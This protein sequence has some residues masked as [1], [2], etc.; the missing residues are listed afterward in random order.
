[1]SRPRPLAPLTAALALAA[2]CGL[3]TASTGFGELPVTTAALDSSSSSSEA[4][5]EA[6]STGETTAANETT[7]PPASTSSTDE[8]TGT[9]AAETGTP[10][11]FGPLNPGC[12]GKI[13][14]L[15]VISSWDS[16]VL[17][18]EALQDAMPAFINILEKDLQDFDYHI[19]VVDAGGSAMMNSICDNCYMCDTCLEPGCTDF[20]GPADYPCDEDTNDCDVIKGAGVTITGNFGA[21]N[22][23]C[24][25]ATD[26]RYLTKAD[27]P[28]LLEK[29]QCIA[30]LGEGPKTPI[31][32]ESLMAA[33][34]PEM[35]EDGGCN[36]G[37]LRDDA[38]LV[39]VI[40]QGESDSLSQGWPESWHDFVVDAKKG[41]A[42]AIV[43][44][45]VSN[46]RDAPNPKCLPAD[47]SPNPLRVFMDMMPHGLFESICA[48]SYVQFLETG[49]ELI[50]EQCSLLVP[51]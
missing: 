30:S 11:D 3:P 46:D 42:D 41:D 36:E 7:N 14:F 10:P 51:Q 29:F 48:A 37:F 26:H 40:V 33:L 15:F 6:E 32:M 50:L 45:V 13:D 34:K 47:D 1:V 21:S 35:L 20:G 22:Q 43:T 44:L 5:S 31:A 25:L 9:T 8:T 4:S 27:A 24:E 18:Q 49:A 38:L 23:R 19:M 12:Q 39:L 28:Q 16:M 2:A 17:H